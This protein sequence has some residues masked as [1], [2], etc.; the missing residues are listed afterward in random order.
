[1]SL[2]KTS[3]LSFI[4]TAVKMIA[5]LVINKTVSLLIGPSGLAVI[6]QFQSA[7][8]IIRILGQGGINAGVTKYTAEYGHEDEKIPKLWS[9]AAKITIFS[10][11]MVGSFI[12]ILSKYLSDIVFSDVQYSYIFIIF[13]FSL[14]LFTINQLLLS[15][16]NGLKEIKT[17]ISINIAQS[18]YSLIFTTLLIYL[19]GLDGALVAMVTNQSFVFIFTL[20]KLRTHKNIILSRFKVKF[21]NKEGR[22]LLSY[23]LMAITSA[24]TVPVSH[25]IIRNYLGEN[26]SWDQAGY[27]Q[28]I[29]YISTMYLMVITTALSTYYLPRL[30]EISSKIELRKEIIEGYKVI[31]PIVVVLSL[32]IYILKDFI[33]WLLFSD[34]FKPMVELF[35]WQLIGDVVKIVSWLVAYLMIAK[36]MTKL[37]ILTEL[38]SS[39][40][41]V[42]LSYYFVGDFGLV[43][44]TYAYALNYLLYFV[45]VTFFVRKELF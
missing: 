17:Y 31:I 8:Q 26:L 39:M 13:G 24:M 14:I 27:W 6:G 30:S 9:T 23:A 15:I 20:F 22:K 11:V 42:A 34:E 2:I 45:V 32:S 1:M 25:F 19:Y 35:K 33:I 5:G 18:V 38:G 36:S 21:D 29:W 37:F 43:G 16:L 7:S 10:S 41:F 12:I 4:A 44:M 40:S 28:A 3:F